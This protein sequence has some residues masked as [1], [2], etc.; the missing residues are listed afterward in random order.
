MLECRDVCL[1]SVLHTRR[2]PNGAHFLS[3][4]PNNFRFAAIFPECSEPERIPTHSVN[5]RDYDPSQKIRSHASPRS[6]SKIVCK[7]TLAP[8]A[9]SC[10]GVNSLGEWL[11]PCTLGTKIIPI[12]PIFAIIC[13]S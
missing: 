9:Q 7:R 1:S 5:E 13:A 10:Q 12:G 8:L 11:M 4:P 6:M 3:S 2:L